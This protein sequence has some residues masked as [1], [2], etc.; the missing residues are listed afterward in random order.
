MHHPARSRFAGQPE[1]H[2]GSLI[3]PGA[4]S[5]LRRWSRTIDLSPLL[6]SQEGGFADAGLAQHDRA[7]RSCQ[8]AV[9]P[10]GGCFCRTG[11]RAC[12]NPGGLPHGCAGPSSQ[13][14]APAPAVSQ[15]RAFPGVL[16]NGIFLFGGVTFSP[17][18]EKE[19]VV[20]MGEGPLRELLL[21]QLLMLLEQVGLGNVRACDAADC[22]RIFV[23]TYRRTFCSLKCQRRAIKRR[24]RQAAR[25]QLEKQ[26]ARTRQR[27]RAATKG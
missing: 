15:Y 10:G 13:P 1:V 24:L 6:K 11:I 7:E 16:G 27:R 17:F 8:A 19:R 22:Q 18:S 14:W 12:P 20:L 23:K 4:P 3:C 26:Q 21:L 2:I 9:R 5:S 25:E